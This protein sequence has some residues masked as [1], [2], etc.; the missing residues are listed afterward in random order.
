M[1]HRRSSFL[2]GLKLSLAVLLTGLLFVQTSLTS[3]A[4]GV[5][6]S[7]AGET[8]IVICGAGGVTTITIAADGTRTVENGG[9]REAAQCP[10]C[11]LS[12]S[13][14][15]D[16]GI[17]LLAIEQRQ[18]RQNASW[19]AISRRSARVDHARAIRAPPPLGQPE[20]RAQR[21]P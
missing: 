8:R 14:V 1:T 13:M 19:P 20:P 12:L 9:E 4:S 6:A 11:L 16:C 18:I 10:F 5:P 21:A 2:S 17:G 7:E 15:P 3:L